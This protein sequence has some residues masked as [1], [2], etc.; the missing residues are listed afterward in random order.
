MTRYI[1]RTRKFGDRLFRFVESSG[2]FTKAQNI[3]KAERRK[4]RLARVTLGSRDLTDVFDVW[5]ANK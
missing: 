4:G 1:S 3:A 5:S 2:S